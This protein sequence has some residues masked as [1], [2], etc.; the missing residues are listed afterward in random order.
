MGD[1]G[2]AIYHVLCVISFSM[3]VTDPCW[4]IL[5][6]VQYGHFIEQVM[7][8]LAPQEPCTYQVLHL[9]TSTK[10][11]LKILN[12]LILCASQWKLSQLCY[13]LYSSP[14]N[15]TYGFEWEYAVLF[16]QPDLCRLLYL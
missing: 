1:D 5:N 10:V 4:L 3:L 14:N 15:H 8:E 11:S 16:P 12:N 6:H 9:S 7:G 2:L 13:F